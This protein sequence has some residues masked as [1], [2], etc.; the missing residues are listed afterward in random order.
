VA[1]FAGLFVGSTWLQGLD[2]LGSNAVET[3]DLLNVSSVAKHVSKA[4][5]SSVK[6]QCFCLDLKT[7]CCF[8]RTKI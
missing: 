4:K 5:Y 6:E 8:Q 7:F 2:N 3:M 1:I